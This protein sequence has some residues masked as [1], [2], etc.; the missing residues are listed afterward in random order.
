[1]MTD[2]ELDQYLAAFQKRMD[3]VTDK[4][5]DLIGEH[6]ADIGQLT[7]SDLHRIKEMRRMGKNM[8]DIEREVAR[9][10]QLNAKDA[11]KLIE[12]SAIDLYGDFAT[13]GIAALS[14]NAAVQAV[15][16]ATAAQTANAM[17]NLSNTTVVSEMYKECI[18]K[19]ITTVQSGVTDY[20]SAMRSTIKEMSQEGLRIQYESGLTR[21]LDTAVRQNILDGTKQI[22]QEMARTVGQ[23]FGADGVEISAHTDC[24][25]DHLFLQGQ[26]MSNKEYERLQRTLDRPLGEWNCRHF[27]FPIILGI[28]QPAYSKKQ[29][30]ELRAQSTEKITIDGVTKTRYQWTQKQRELETNVRYAKNE[31]N[32]CKAAGDS[33]G[34]R[35][36]QAK[37]N[38]IDVLYAKVSSEAGIPTRRERMQV[39]GFMRVK[40]QRAVDVNASGWYNQHISGNIV[41]EQKYSAAL[42]AAKAAPGIKGTL[43]KPIVPDFMKEIGFDAQHILNERNHRVTKDEAISFIRDAVVMVE[44]DKGRYRDYFSED[45]AAYTLT[46]KKLIRTA[47][48]EAE[49]VPEVRTMM[50]VILDGIK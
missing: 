10:T 17:T 41:A 23:Q 26:Q 29:L 4:Y 5:I 30:A 27:A 31:A 45:G 16:K 19:A 40:A 33:V 7:A 11:K 49:Y 35:N 37:M 42:E 44:R 36:A 47:F 8:D 12:Q 1:M 22:N 24:A 3:A 21:R 48:F 20:Q 14:G 2:E 34:R 32:A 28:S 39:A 43:K 13:Y 46:S 38:D 6:V 50:E 25:P 18:D 9:V 15:I